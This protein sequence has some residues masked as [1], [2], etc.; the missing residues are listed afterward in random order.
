MGSEVWGF[1]RGKLQWNLIHLI[2]LKKTVDHYD[3]TESLIQQHICA[4]SVAVDNLGDTAALKHSTLYTRGG[5]GMVQPVWWLVAF[6]RAPDAPLST[7]NTSLL[8][9]ILAYIYIKMYF[10]V[11]ACIYPAV[12]PKD[13][14]KMSWKKSKA[15]LFKF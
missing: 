5:C 1:L 10:E 7:F 9:S 8:V 13:V 6:T 4:V 3:G 14:T 12:V 15:C 11:T 2:L